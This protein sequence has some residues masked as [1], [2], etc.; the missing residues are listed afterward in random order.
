MGK[1]TSRWKKPTVAQNGDEGRVRPATALSCIKCPR[2]HSGCGGRS[3]TTATWPAEEI[4]NIA[5]GP[6]LF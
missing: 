4:L 2:R 1:G 3:F 5:T 6:M